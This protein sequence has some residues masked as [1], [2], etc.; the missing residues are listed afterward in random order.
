MTAGVAVQGAGLAEP[1]SKP[2]L[3]IS[4]TVP[5]VTVRVTVV[6]WVMAP[7]VPV[8]VIVE[9]PAVA[10]AATEMVM[11]E[12]PEPRAAMEAELGDA[13]IVKSGVG[14]L[15]TVRLTV[16][17]WVMLPPVPVMVTVEVP[18]VAVPPT[19]KVSVELPEPGAAIGLGLKAAVTPAGRP[20]AES[21]MAEL[22]PPE[23]AVVIVEVPVLPC[24]IETEAG[25]AAIVKS[26]V[27]VGLGV[28]EMQVE[29]AEAQASLPVGKAVTW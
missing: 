11:V 19:V 1:F 16:V 5:V 18:R 29:G 2:G 4:C 22:K 7:P 28:T 24:T 6:V 12:L 15:V 20:E 23:T 17:V 26:G 9:V 13:E 21:E 8:M 10:E 14:T 3:P 25:A 27:T